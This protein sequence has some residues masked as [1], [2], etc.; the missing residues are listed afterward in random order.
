MIGS[1]PLAVLTRT[2]SENKHNSYSPDTSRTMADSFCT[3]LFHVAAEERVHRLAS[4][5][6]LSVDLRLPPEQLDTSPNS[7]SSLRQILNARAPASR[8]NPSPGSG[9]Y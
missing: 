6:P 9:N 2:F 5:N 4:R 1:L 7:F 8:S 3:A